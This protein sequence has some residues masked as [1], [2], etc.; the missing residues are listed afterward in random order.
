MAHFTALI[1]GKFPK[2]KAQ[3][4]ISQMEYP[5]IAADISRK[6]ATKSDTDQIGKA[7]S[8]ASAN[9]NANTPKSVNALLLSNPGGVGP[10]FGS[11]FAQLRVPNIMG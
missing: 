4:P 1:Y 10:L 8:M 7:A 9:A 2:R 6:T 5:Y 3:Q 11:S